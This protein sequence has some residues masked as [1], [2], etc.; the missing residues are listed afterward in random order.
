MRLDDPRHA[1]GPPGW[2]ERLDARFKLIFALGFVVV[3]VATPFGAWRFLGALGL[4]LALLIGLA[5][6]SA[7]TLFFRWAG[8]AV[9]VGFLSLMVAPGLP[10]RAEHGL[11]VVILTLLAKNSLAFLMMLVLG[12]VTLWRELLR[13]MRRLGVPGVLVATLQFM[14]R[15][16]HVL[17]D[18]LQRMTRARRA[19]SC[20]PAG[21]LAWR[22]LSGLV[23]SLLLR[24]FDRSERVHW[25]MLARGWDG[26][27]RTL[28]D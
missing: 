15:Y 6:I 28:D 1:T 21:L 12:S 8:F 22:S 10:A 4:L 17:L 25:A 18:E 26:T 13:A 7:R 23:G 2:L 3:V 20:G 19:R 16:L 9:V 11:L 5:G 14:E 24:S 27:I